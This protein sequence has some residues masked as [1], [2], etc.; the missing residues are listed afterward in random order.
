MCPINRISLIFESTKSNHHCTLI[1]FTK[2]SCTF[3]RN[4]EIRLLNARRKNPL[5]LS[6]FFEFY[7]IL[8]SHA[9]CCMTMVNFIK[10]IQ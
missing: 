2:V 5:N 9:I 7:I 8:V 4:K 10:L 1:K 6:L 3:M